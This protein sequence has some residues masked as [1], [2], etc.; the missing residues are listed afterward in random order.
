[1]R[2]EEILSRQ[3]H[4]IDLEKV[5]TIKELVESF[6][7]AS[8]Q[9]RALGS[10]ASV[11]ERM[12]TAETRPT[13]FIGLSGALIAGGLRKVIRD[14]IEHNLADVVVST[15]AIVYQ[16]FYQA[17]GYQHYIG[18]P[19]MDDVMLRG[20]EIDRIYD[21]LVDEQKFEET[22]EFICGTMKKLEPKAYSSREILRILGDYAKNDAGSILGTANE[23]GVPVFSPALNDSSIGIG[24]TMYHAKHRKSPHVML[25]SIKDNYELLSIIRHSKETGV[26]YVGGGTP[27]NWVN[28]G[29]VMAN[30]VFQ[31]E[32]EGHTYAVQLTT[33]APHWGGLSGSTLKE[34]QSWGKVH[35][36][37][38]R[39]TAYLEATVGLPLLVGYLIHS[40][41]AERRKRLR[42]EWDD[43]GELIGMATA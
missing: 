26:V 38:R 21:T 12:L 40:G 4:Q 13:I 16:D 42:F 6:K 39:A 18:E 9:A 15:G 20:M 41:A 19:S 17:L 33:D 28:D 10:C 36:D 2:R 24:M 7:G 8:I 11:W 30:Y 32:V 35:R 29:V 1:M 22:D 23:H 5:S 27:K 3:V 34:A 31:R 25:D 43:T 37:A 14:V